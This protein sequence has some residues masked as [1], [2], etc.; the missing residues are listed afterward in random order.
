MVEI[1]KKSFKPF[2]ISGNN[3]LEW[4]SNVLLHIQTQDIKHTIQEILIIERDST[5]TT[6]FGQDTSKPHKYTKQ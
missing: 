1:I 2:D 4:T 6:M 3:F 5:V